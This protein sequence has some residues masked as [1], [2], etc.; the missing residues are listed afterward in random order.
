MTVLDQCRVRWGRVLSVDG[1]TVTVR[2]RGLTLEGH[3]LVEGPLRVGQV[4]RAVDGVGWRSRCLRRDRGVALGLGVSEAFSRSA[5]ASAD[6]DEPHVG[7]C[8]RSA[9]TGASGRL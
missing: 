8:Q 5:S 9:H 1:D 6:L 4:R 3:R 2:D 7:G